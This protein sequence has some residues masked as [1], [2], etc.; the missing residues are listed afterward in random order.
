MFIDY[1]NILEITPPVTEQ[2]IKNAY[3]KQC[4]KWHPD[5]NPN[6]DTTLIMQNIIEAYIFLKDIEGR[7][8]YDE[9]Y[10]T[11]KEHQKFNKKN[12]KSS[13]SSTNRKEHE[14]VNNECL[15]NE[16]EFEF[17]DEILK[18]WMKNAKEQA[19]NIKADV[20]DEFKGTTIESGKSIVNYFLY[21]FIP[22]II[23]FLLI[24]TCNR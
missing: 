21:T 15:N 12:E 24:K 20:I 19:N 17:S 8:R 23:G 7:K 18:K 14:Y 13:N 2:E 16:Y 22:M 11:F 3:R 10:Y 5:K 4:L 9:A 1:Y 6:T